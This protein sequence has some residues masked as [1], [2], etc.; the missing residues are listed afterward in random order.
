MAVLIT[1]AIV[2]GLAGVVFGAY[3][4]VCLAIRR[5]DRG[6]KWSLRSNAASQSARSARALVGLTSSRWK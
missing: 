6:A 5:E 1:I 4:R 2:M 3:I